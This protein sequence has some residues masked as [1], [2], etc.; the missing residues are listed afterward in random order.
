MPLACTIYEVVGARELREVAGR[1]AERGLEITDESPARVRGIAEL[2][3]GARARFALYAFRGRIFL[4]A[5]AGRRLAARVARLISQAA[6][7]ELV[8]VRVDPLRFM[9]LYEGAVVKVAVFDMVRA[10][11]LRH[12][13]LIGDAVSDSDAYREHLGAGRLKYVLFQTGR[14]LVLGVSESGI[15]IALSRL[16]EDELLSIVEGELLPLAAQ[17]R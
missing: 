1:L 6:S 16:G 4:V 2:P 3:D 13:V 15:V 9:Q 10:L 11:G 8:E 14:G 17:A 12:V 7:V 5:M